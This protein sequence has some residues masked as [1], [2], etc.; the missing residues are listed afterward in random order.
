MLSTSVTSSTFVFNSGCQSCKIH[1]MSACGGKRSIR[2]SFT[3]SHSIAIIPCYARA[4]SETNICALLFGPGSSSQLLQHPQISELF[5]SD[6]ISRA[7]VLL[8]AIPGGVGAYRCVSSIVPGIIPGSNG[9]CL[10]CH[11]CL[12]QDPLRKM[13][14]H[15]PSL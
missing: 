13:C 9:C 11:E 5:P 14:K 3:S 6:V 10:W 7:T 1:V 8:K 2:L 4:W 15:L 12:N